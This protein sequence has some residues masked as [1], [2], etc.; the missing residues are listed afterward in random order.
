VTD[1]PRKKRSPLDKAYIAMRK[2]EGRKADAVF[3]CRLY[4]REDG[5]WETDG[6]FRHW[7]KDLESED[8]NALPAGVP[9]AVISAVSSKPIQKH[10]GKLLRN[11]ASVVL[12]PHVGE[13]TAN[14]I[15][16][17]INNFTSKD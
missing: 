14:M 7:L 12:A 10:V 17:I 2:G 1:T 3:V 11:A 16:D 4:K 8:K 5:S 9:G 6:S 15:G 13:N